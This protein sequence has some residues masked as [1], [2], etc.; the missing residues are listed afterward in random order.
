MQHVGVYKHKV[1]LASIFLQKHK[2]ISINHQMGY[3]GQN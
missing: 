1:L 2:T 3:N